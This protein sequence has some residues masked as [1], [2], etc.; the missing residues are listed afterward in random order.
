MRV[1][2]RTWQMLL[3]GMSEVQHASRPIAAA[4]M[5]LV[6]IAY[7]ADLPTPDEAIRALGNG[8]AETGFRAAQQWRQRCRMRLQAACRWHGPSR[9]AALRARR[10]HAA[11]KSAAR[12][13]GG[14]RRSAS[15]DFEELVKL[16]TDR[17]DLQ[18]KAALERDVRLVRCEDGKLEIALEAGRV[19]IRWSTN[20]RAKIS[21]WTGRKWFVTLSREPGQPTLKSQADARE[22]ELKRGVRGDPLVQ[23]VLERFPGAE[24]VAVRPREAEPPAADEPR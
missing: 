5:L 14:C 7:A 24:I 23:A 15:A 8:T 6:R 18:I 1:L 13:A 12:H 16:A 21:G 19:V 20:C 9:R 17:R 3:K 4:E 2:S 22:A 11:V 10:S